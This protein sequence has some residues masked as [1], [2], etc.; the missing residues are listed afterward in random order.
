[1]G[2]I[3]CHLL[4]T[5]GMVVHGSQHMRINQ[6]AKLTCS[7]WALLGEIVRHCPLSA[8]SAEHQADLHR[9][10]DAGFV[11]VDQTVMCATRLGM[12]AF[13]YHHLH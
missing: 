3:T 13:W 8:C 2:Q 4:F 11:A 12:E 10:V 1:M 5:A 7:Q 6:L 9:L